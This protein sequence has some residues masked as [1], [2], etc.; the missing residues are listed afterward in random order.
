M[1]SLPEQSNQLGDEPRMLQGTM[2]LIGV[3]SSLDKYIAASDI[4]I[5][6][7]GLTEEAFKH[8]GITIKWK[9]KGLKETGVDEKTGVARVKIDPTYFRPNEVNYLQG[10]ASKARRVL[11]WKPKVQFKE[12]VRRMVDSDLRADKPW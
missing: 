3:Q 4:V 2:R 7:N 10:D 6:W 1:H 5:R 8:V 11:G 12:L 9:G